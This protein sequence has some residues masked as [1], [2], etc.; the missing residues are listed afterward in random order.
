MAKL[1]VKNTA[2]MEAYRKKKIAFLRG[3]TTLIFFVVLILGLTY[4]LLAVYGNSNIK[5]VDGVLK[6]TIHFTSSKSVDYTLLS[7]LG[8]TRQLKWFDGSAPLLGSWSNNQT[9][10]VNLIVIAIV[11]VA[12]LLCLAY[13]FLMMGVENKKY[14]TF[15]WETLSTL[16][17]S[18]AQLNYRNST[19]VSNSNDFKKASTIALGENDITT[20]FVYQLSKV[21][22]RYNL[23]TVSYPV[24]NKK[25]YS[26]IAINA[27]DRSNIDGFLQIRT[28]GKLE[29]NKLPFKNAIAEETVRFKDLNFRVYSTFNFDKFSED[30]P[31]FVKLVYTISK[32]LPQG[33]VITVEKNTISFCVDDF[34]MNLARSIRFSLKNEYL[35]SQ[36]LSMSRLYDL[37]NGV[38]SILGGNDV[39]LEAPGVNISISFLDPGYIK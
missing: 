8:W 18:K 21:S 35:E 24:D 26:M 31:S 9:L 17:K 6:G 4:V 33:F 2:E 36:I 29:R 7:W 28:F 1:L 19:K 38:T 15:Y 25:R 39:Q 32:F 3:I 13:Y 34:K 22:T 37:I 14:M 30:R 5:E 23:S 20:E 27:S 16:A 10:M 12:L 11:L